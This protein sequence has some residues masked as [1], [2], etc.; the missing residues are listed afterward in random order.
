MVIEKGPRL[1]PVSYNI[2]RPNEKLTHRQCK[3]VSSP[4]CVSSCKAHWWNQWRVILYKNMFAYWLAVYWNL[5][6]INSHSIN[7]NLLLSKN[8]YYPPSVK[9]IKLQLHSCGPALTDCSHLVE[10]VGQLRL[11]NIDMDD[12]MNTSVQRTVKYSRFCLC[13]IC[14]NKSSNFHGYSSS[15]CYVGR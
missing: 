9:P 8:N 15:I 1:S 13:L 2:L 3:H 10:T 14:L 11:R 12:F 6:S 7:R 4:L 5:S